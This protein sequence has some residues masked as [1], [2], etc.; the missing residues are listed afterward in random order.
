MNLFM[1]VPNKKEEA[2]KEWTDAKTNKSFD[3][4]WTSP[5]V[6]RGGSEIGYFCG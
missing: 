4:F 5:V 3:E 1:Q 6:A 2:S